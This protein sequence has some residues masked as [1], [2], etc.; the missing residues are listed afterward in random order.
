M[1]AAVVFFPKHFTS[2]DDNLHMPPTQPKRHNTLMLSCVERA[3]RKSHALAKF[4]GVSHSQMYMAR[5]RSIGAKNAGKIAC[6][7]ASLLGLSRMEK[8]ELKAEIVGHS[9]NLPC[10]FAEGNPP[11]EKARLERDK[12]ESTVRSEWCQFTYLYLGQP[13]PVEADSKRTS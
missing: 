2:K 8:L 13:T 4:F 9:D 10:A 12:H 11:R 5:E 1:I 6:G 7:M 3:D